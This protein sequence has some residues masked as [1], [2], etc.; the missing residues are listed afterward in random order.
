VH[1]IDLTRADM[2]PIEFAERVQPVLETCGEDVVRVGELRVEGS[3]ERTSRGYR[4]EGRLE[5]TMTLRCVRC[6]GEF[7][8]RLAERLEIEL[9]PVAS[10]P[11]E[12]ETRLGRDELDVVFFEAPALDLGAIAG[13]QVLLAVPMK[14]LC[15]E[16]CK[17]LCSR[18]GKSLNEGACDC[19]PQTDERWA[20]LAQ[21]RDAQ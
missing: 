1:V 6:L 13:E 2:Q 20:P 5:G 19:P 9:L 11:R 16:G 7:Q 3:V 18:C 21:W 12:E 4:L 10:A 17:G 8:V 14:P 15:R